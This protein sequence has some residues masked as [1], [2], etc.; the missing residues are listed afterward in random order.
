LRLLDSF[1]L[2]QWGASIEK[3]GQV[4][5]RGAVD[6]DREGLGNELVAL[7]IVA[8]L[9][10]AQHNDSDP[11]A[12]GKPCSAPGLVKTSTKKYC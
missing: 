8:E 6:A 12:I 7:S 10:T 11:H 9:M 4:A 3:E 5:G 2:G 1:L